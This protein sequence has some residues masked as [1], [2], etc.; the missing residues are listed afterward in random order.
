MKLIDTHCRLFIDPLVNDIEGVLARAGAA[1]IDKIVVPA[2]DVQSWDVIKQLGRR[3][4]VLPA[5]GLHPLSASQ[6]DTSDAPPA[7][8]TSVFLASSGSRP[9]DSDSG[10]PAA[11]PVFQS[12]VEFQDQLEIDII[13]CGAVAIGEIGL[14][15]TVKRPT[16]TEQRAVLKAQ[17]ELAVDLDLPVILSCRNGWELLVATLQPLAGKIRGVLH[18]YTRT[19]ELAYPFLGCGF[20]VSFSGA[21]SQPMIERARRSAEVLPLDKILLE[22][23]AP[24]A[25]LQGIDAAHSEPRHLL[26][27]AKAL[28]GIRNTPIETIAEITSSNVRKLFRI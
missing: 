10:K 28:A 19:P 27:V 23:D 2:Y 3:D 24:R 5:L 4:G 12:L 7:N 9:D 11:P 6:V 25:G 26:D 21:I 1:G 22:T 20:F 13:E 17:L 18:G 8:I 14:D 16:P 15:L